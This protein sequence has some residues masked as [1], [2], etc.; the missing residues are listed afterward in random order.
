MEIIKLF[1]VAFLFGWA[2]FAAIPQDLIGEILQDYLSGEFALD[3]D[4]AIIRSLDTISGNVVDYEIPTGKSIETNR[5]VINVHE[6]RY[7]P[8]NPLMDSY[9]FVEINQ[10]SDGAEIFNAWLISKLPA[11]SSVEHPRYDFWLIRC[12]T[13]KPEEASGAEVN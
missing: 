9:A 10:K 5:F 6:C 12:T 1:L 8:E 2:G 11:I 3:G 13:S 4:S 7:L